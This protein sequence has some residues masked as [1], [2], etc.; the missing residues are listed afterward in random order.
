MNP[1]GVTTTRSLVLLVCQFRHFR[2][3]LSFNGSTVIIIALWR[4]F[5]NSFLYFLIFCRIDQIPHKSAPPDPGMWRKN[6]EGICLRDSSCGRR[7]LNPHERNAH[8]NLNLARLPIPTLPHHG[9]YNT[10]FFEE[11]QTFFIKL[12]KKIHLADSLQTT[13]QSMI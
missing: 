12:F 3:P 8:K 7:D 6:P 4:W 9:C 2:E 13:F 10:S 1:H 11:C 5:V